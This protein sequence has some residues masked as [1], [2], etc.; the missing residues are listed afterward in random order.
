MFATRQPAGENK[1]GGVKDGRV[2]RLHK[3]GETRR[4]HTTTGDATTSPQTRGEREERHPRTRGDGA[5]MGVE[6]RR[7]SRAESRGREAEA[8]V[9]QPS[10]KQETSAVAAKAT[11]TAMVMATGNAARRYHGT[12]WQRLPWS[13]RLRLWP[14]SLRMMPMVATSVS[15]L[16]AGLLSWQ[17]AG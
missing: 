10:G 9:L 1:E 3:K 7:Q 4:R 16:S 14:H 8:S 13:S 6:K 11:A 2:R 15:P 17:E 5:S 12:C